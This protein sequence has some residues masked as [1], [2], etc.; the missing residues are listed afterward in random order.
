MSATWPT[1][2]QLIRELGDV[3]ALPNAE[4]EPALAEATMAVGKATAALTR[5]AQVRGRFNEAAVAQALEAV[6]D[7]RAALQ[8]ARAAIAASAARRRPRPSP[9]PPTKLDA[10]VEGVAEATCPA[11]EVALVVRY[12]ATTAGPVVAFPVA[13]PAADCDGV[14]EVAYPAST[15]EVTVEAAPPA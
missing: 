15:V 3:C 1:L 5:A 2:D 7:A 13:C 9:A 6:E 14:M 10:T 12:R 8:R 4:A 11:C